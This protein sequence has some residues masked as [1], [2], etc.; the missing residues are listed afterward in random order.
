MIFFTYIHPFSLEP[1]I[2]LGGLNVTHNQTKDH[3]KDWEQLLSAFANMWNQEVIFI[4]GLNFNKFA[5]RDYTQPS[6]PY[7]PPFVDQPCRRRILIIQP[8]GRLVSNPVEC[9]FTLSSHLEDTASHSLSLPCPE[10]EVPRELLLHRSELIPS[11][12]LG[13]ERFE[14]NKLTLREEEGM[15]IWVRDSIISRK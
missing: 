15:I 3:L 1:L 14:K 9:D 7:L 12:V 2:G 5:K 6:F 10:W 8:T 11:P 4:H 13:T